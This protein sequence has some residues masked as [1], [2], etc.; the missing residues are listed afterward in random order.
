MR[1]GFEHINKARSF[2]YRRV[3]YDVCSYN[4]NTL[5][6]AA[7]ISLARKFYWVELLVAMLN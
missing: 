3:P 6:V 7:V 4:F 2:K 5:E 1:T